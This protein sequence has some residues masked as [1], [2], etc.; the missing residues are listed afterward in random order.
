LACS[1]TVGPPPLSVPVSF[2]CPTP[3][4][5]IFNGNI[6]FTSPQTDVASIR[7]AVVGTKLAK[8]LPPATSTTESCVIFSA[9][10]TVTLPDAASARSA[11]CTVS[12]SMSP[13]VF[14][15]RALPPIVPTRIKPLSTRAV[16]VPVQRDTMMLPK[17]TLASTVP[18]IRLKFTGPFSSRAFIAPFRLPT[19][20]LPL[21]SFT[22]RLQARGTVTKNPTSTRVSPPTVSRRPDS[23]GLCAVTAIIPPCSRKSS[24]TPSIARAAA[25]SSF[26]S[27]SMVTTMRTTA[28]SLSSIITAPRFESIVSVPPGASANSRRTSRGAA[29]RTSVAA[30]PPTSSSAANP[31]AVR[32]NGE[33]TEIMGPSQW[34]PPA[35]PQVPRTP[36]FYARPGVALRRT[37]PTSPRSWQ[38]KGAPPADAPASPFPRTSAP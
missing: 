3:P 31:N 16:T 19:V 33:K 4:A 24:F 2:R 17:S 37:T 29:A 32:R 14:L 34:A 21:I 26:A 23:C 9:N 36:R 30:A 6:A 18:S 20:M 10:P 15:S 28:S 11:P 38:K 8:I 13:V 7:H 35:R 5:S 22:S 25:R 1:F 12:T 27:A